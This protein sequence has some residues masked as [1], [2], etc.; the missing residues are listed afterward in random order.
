MTS[1]KELFKDLD[2]SFKSKV[3][4][5]NGAYLEVKGKG[6]VSTD[7]CAGTKL[8]TK[9]LFISEI[10]QNLLNVGQLVEKEFKVLFEEGKCLISDSNGNELFK[11]NMQHKSFSLNLLEEEQVAFKCQ[12]NDTKFWHKRLGIFISKG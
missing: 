8:I 3:K 7:S 12:V 10:D 11:I 2:I 5:G 1:D 4:I 6:T 9:V